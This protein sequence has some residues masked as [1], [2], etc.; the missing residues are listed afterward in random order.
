MQNA[1][2][3]HESIL[4]RGYKSASV[5]GTYVNDIPNLVGGQVSDFSDRSN[6]GNR[7]MK[8]RNLLESPY[9]SDDDAKNWGDPYKDA[10]YSMSDDENALTHGNIYSPLPSSFSK[11][12]FPIAQYAPRMN[13]SVIY[14]NITE[15]EFKENCRNET[16]NGGF[17]AKYGVD[18]ESLRFKFEAC[19][20]TDLRN[21]PWK[22]T[23]DRQDI[24][25]K[26][27]LGLGL[28]GISG[29]SLDMVYWKLEVGTSLGYFE[30]PSEQNNNK[31]GRLLDKDPLAPGSAQIKE[32]I[33]RRA[34]NVS[35]FGNDTLS[36]ETNIGP[37]ASVALALFGRWSFVES[38]MSDPSR[39]ILPYDYLEDG[40][41]PTGTRDCVY[42]FPMGNWENYVSQKC[43]SHWESLDER[44]V[45][46]QVRTYLKPFYSDTTFKY[47]LQTNL[48]HAIYMANKLWL[49]GTYPRGSHAQLAVAF[50]AGIP[51]IKPKISLAGMIVGSI[52]LAAHLLGLLLLAIYVFM[53]KPWSDTMGAEVMLKMG[54]VYSDTLAQSQ[55]KKEWK[56][57]LNNLPGYISD[58]KPNEQVGRLGLGAAAGL[59]RRKGRQF[60]V[61]K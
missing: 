1:F 37:L 41:Y 52:F 38:R 19:M 48:N 31:P 14:V 30:L 39:F 33:Y 18:T 55:T 7:M 45:Y 46:T 53:M 2:V 50:D 6:E 3:E 51:V 29:A 5:T 59:S 24:T 15:N 17:Y 44:D 4:A 32:G 10:D 13:S 61:L 28:Y 56:E 42:K 23:R 12:A 16:D 27:Y 8:L 26:L 47:E 21:T 58:E 43:V 35:Y 9:S 60:E 57:T 36:Q 20:P 49:G 22:V 54:M 34:D 11:N 40:I 25:E